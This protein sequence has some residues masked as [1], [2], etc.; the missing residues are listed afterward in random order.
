MQPPA[1]PA[2]R[3]KIIQEHFAPSTPCSYPPSK[4]PGNLLRHAF[5]PSN[6]RPKIAQKLSS[7][8]EP[9]KP[10]RA[11]KNNGFSHPHHETAFSTGRSPKPKTSVHQSLMQPPAN[12][13]SRPKIIQKQFVPSTRCSCPPSKAPGNLLRHAF[14]PSKSRP[15]IVEK[16]SSQ[17]GPG[18]HLR[19]AKRLV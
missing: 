2:S 10:L 13:T 1:S 8:C 11:G 17:C 18:K 6:S 12:P 5:P 3:P 7:Q 4:A 9:G 15:K 16:L 14:P 19:A